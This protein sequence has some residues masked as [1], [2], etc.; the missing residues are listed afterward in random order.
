MRAVLIGAASV[1]AQAWRNGGGQTRELLAWPAQGEWQ[2]RVSRADIDRDGPFSAFPGVERWFA[3]LQGEGV[4]LGF[5][6]GERSIRSTDDALHFDGAAAP[7]CRLLGGPTQDLNLMLRGGAGAMRRWC[8]GQPWDEGFAMR[9][10]YTTVAGR[11]SGGAASVDLA[12]D[13]LMW[14]EAAPGGPWTFQP[15]QAHA[16]GSAWWLGFTPRS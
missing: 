4:V 13:T 10:L 12:A 11:C 15:V 5:G 8:A 1:P 2:L 9:G 6:T 3:V 16:P 14:S 7:A